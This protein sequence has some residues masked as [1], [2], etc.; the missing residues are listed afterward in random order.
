MD[1]SESPPLRESPGIPA[2]LRRHCQQAAFLWTLR[3]R[4]L[5]RPDVGLE[6]LS[7]LDERLEAQL[8]GIRTAQARGWRSCREALADAGCGEV[9]V[10][11]LMGLESDARERFL[12]LLDAV[13]A[14]PAWWPA[15]AGA[16]AWASA[17][18][19]QG[20]A[21]L[22]LESASPLRRRA[23]VA[24]CALHRVD[25][26][27]VLRTLCNDEA[28]ATAARALRAAGELGRG[29][30][31]DECLRHLR[32]PHAELRFWAGWAA[33]ML[34]D[35]DDAL[36]ALARVVLEDDLRRP[37]ALRTLLRAAP[38]EQC[39]QLLSRL[40]R[41]PA[42]QRLLLAGIGWLGDVHYVPWLI[43]Q[44]QQPAAARQ[45]GESWLLI[46]GADIVDSALQGEAAS[47]PDCADDVGLPVPDARKLAAWWQAHGGGL[48]AGTPLFLGGE[49]SAERCAGVLRQGKQRQRMLAA[50]MLALLR[51]GRVLFEPRAPAWRQH[52]LLARGP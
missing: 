37:R 5:Q 47:P 32:S 16:L 42:S 26:G 14:E 13:D 6:D 10:A 33:V 51:P 24:A 34:G 44:A 50:E 35:R 29:D 1:L 39:R 7:A 41:E 31:R 49:P 19:L 22:L 43:A 28:P 48:R 18:D 25:P 45:V 2:L 27:A 52:H 40:A 17:Q 46:T 30:L 12:P 9:F 3:H 8:E 4:Y 23:G 11:C 36:R 15:C 21:R 38:L 20:V